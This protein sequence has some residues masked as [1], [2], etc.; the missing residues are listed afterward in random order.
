MAD[1]KY[2][3]P[4][5]GKTALI[6]ESAEAA[7]VCPQCGR[8]MG[9]AADVARSTEAPRLRL[10]AAG[11]ALT[12][13]QGRVAPTPTTLSAKTEIPA[14]NPVARRV[15][16]APVPRRCDLGRIMSSLAVA[17][18]VAAL[19]W[20]FRRAVREPEGAAL[21]VA[22]RW[23]AVALPWLMVAVVAM[24][25]SLL[26]GLGCLLIPGY[27]VLYSMRRVE[28]TWL[29]YLVLAAI[30]LLAAEYAWWRERSIVLWVSRGVDEFIAGGSRLLQRAGEPEY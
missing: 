1:V 22:V 2:R 13:V 19:A 12:D 26:Q 15:S 17:A 30:A 20:L 5:C 21:Y 24:Q 9:K 28:Q 6:S 10:A 7:P 4:D 3:C 14:T 18:Y 8:P 16:A 23:A 29:R 11:T 25:E 27:V